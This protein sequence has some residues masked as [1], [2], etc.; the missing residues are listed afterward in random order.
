MLI[1]KSME[2]PVRS[3]RFHFKERLKAPTDRQK[4]LSCQS[5]IYKNDITILK[6]LKVNRIG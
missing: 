5:H 4:N 3:E 2:G 1:K 6:K